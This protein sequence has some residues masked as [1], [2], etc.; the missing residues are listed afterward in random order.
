MASIR[1]SSLHKVYGKTPAVRGVD[2]SIGTGEFVVILGPSGCGKST[3]LRMI[4]GLEDITSGVVAIDDVIVNDLE[5]G[6]RGC[7]MVFQNYALYPHMSVSENIGYSLKVA[8]VARAE[9]DEKIRRVA[10]LLGLDTF[11]D[12]RPA[13]LSGGQRQRVAMGRAMIRSPRVFLF[14]EPLS[15]LDAKLRLQMRLEIKRL[16][17][18]LGSTSIFVTHD[19]LEA[20][21]LA[22]RL[23]VMNGGKIEQVGTPQEIYRRPASLFVADFLGSPPMNF[24]PAVIDDEGK[25]VC[26]DGLRPCPDLI[27]DLEPGAEVRIGVRPGDLQI[28]GRSARGALPF[29]VE[30]VEDLGTENHLHGTTT[31]LRMTAVLATG[32]AVPDHPFAVLIPESAVHLFR[33]RDGARIDPRSVSRIH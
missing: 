17:R 15:N 24:I 12:R 22:D 30:M 29:E 16:H 33:E 14:D 2:L 31:G 4:A 10:T 6:D 23:V 8:G 21:T 19:Q 5:P 11:L 25:A 3:L 26:A 32:E 20:M 13:Q 7:A 18:E 27:W 9:R 28:V 1:I